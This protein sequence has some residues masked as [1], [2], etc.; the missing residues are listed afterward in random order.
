[1]LKAIQKGTWQYLIREFV[2]NIQGAEAAPYQTFKDGCLYQRIIDIIRQND[3]W[4][5]VTHLKSRAG[6]VL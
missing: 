4:V 2:N 5:D 3:T 6:R 1:M